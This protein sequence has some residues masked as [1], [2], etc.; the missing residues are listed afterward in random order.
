MLE[1]IKK[2]EDDKK[3]RAVKFPKDLNELKNKLES[4]FQLFVEGHT[5]AVSCLAIT[6][7]DKFIVSGSFDNTLKI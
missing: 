7:D 3:M 1:R 4:D 5:K 6:H 2:I